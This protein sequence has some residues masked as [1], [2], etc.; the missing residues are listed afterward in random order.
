MGPVLAI[1]GRPNVGKSTFFNRLTESRAAIVES[2]SGVTR[3]RHYGES[4]W[5]GMQ[6]SVIDTG[7]YVIGSD[8]I[9]EEEIRKQVNLAIDESDVI[10]FVV[11]V[12]TGITGMDEDVANILRRTK[13]KVVVAVNKVDNNQRIHDAQEFYGLGLGEIYC[14]SSING[15][16]TGDLLDAVVK[17]FPEQVETEEEDDDIPKYAVVGRPNVGKSSLINALI[18]KERNIVTPIA[19][20]TRDTVNTRYN[21]FGFDFTLVDTAGLRKKAKVNE[22]IEFYSVL[23]SIRAIENSDVCLL[24]IDAKEGFEGQDQNIFHLAEKNRKGIVIIVNKWDLIDKETNTHLEFEKKIREKIAP[25][26][27]VP[28]VF[29]SVLNKQ[30]IFKALEIAHQVYKNKSTRITTSELNEVMLPIIEKT[31]PPSGSR[32]RYIKFKYVT[33]LP[34]KFPAFAFFCNFPD[35]VKDAYA[36]FLENQ[37]REKYGFTGVPVQIYFRQK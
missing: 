37:I 28:I 21:S 7:G 22:N 3:D 23:R 25:F 29:T 13:K 5:N 34:T 11:D 8:D 2:T 4:D 14:I 16:G 31:P 36:R 26:T 35:E 24:L 33:Q 20:T 1:V 19:G 9:F 10:V 12:E 30:R 32:G 17:E 6:F 15:S 18:G 27:D